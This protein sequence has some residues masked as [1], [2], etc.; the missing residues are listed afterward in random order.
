MNLN[1]PGLF[2]F[3]H[4]LNIYVEKEVKMDQTKMDPKDLNSPHQELSVCGLRFVVVL[5]GPLA[6]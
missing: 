3:G 1:L 4:Y 6:N 2:L 5:F